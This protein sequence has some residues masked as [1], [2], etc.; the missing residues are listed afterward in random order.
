VTRRNPTFFWKIS[1]P[2]PSERNFGNERLHSS[3]RPGAVVMKK[4]W[5][6]VKRSVDYSLSTEEE[7]TIIMILGATDRTRC[8]R[9]GLTGMLRSILNALGREEGA[10]SPLDHDSDLLRPPAFLAFN[11]IRLWARSWCLNVQWPFLNC[12][13]CGCGLDVYDGEKLAGKY[14]C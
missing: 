5:L 13:G 2:D 14:L 11:T 1:P 8:A 7:L 9:G 3:L 4:G 6:R 10:V 12:V